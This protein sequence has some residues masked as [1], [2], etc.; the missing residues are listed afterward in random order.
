M[1][2][3]FYLSGSRPDI[4]SQRCARVS[5]A[6]MK[7][8]VISTLPFT[9]R[10]PIVEAPFGKLQPVQRARILTLG[11]SHV[12]DSRLPVGDRA[13]ES[14]DITQAGYGAA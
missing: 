11:D 13:N 12:T 14:H 6:P 8:E 2:L 7:S 4:I 1:D 10:C 9:I 5:S 3:I